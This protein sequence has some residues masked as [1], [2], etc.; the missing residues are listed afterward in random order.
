MWAHLGSIFGIHFTQSSPRVTG[1]AARVDRWYDD[2]S[3][4]VSFR[5]LAASIFRWRFGVVDIGCR[6]ASVD[7][8]FRVSTGLFFPCRHW[9]AFPGPVG[10][11]CR[12]VRWSRDCPNAVR[13]CC[14]AVTIR[15]PL[16]GAVRVGGASAFANPGQLL[17][18]RRTKNTLADVRQNRRE[19]RHAHALRLA[20]HETGRRLVATRSAIEV[21]ASCSRICSF[22]Y[23]EWQTR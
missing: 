4:D 18:N 1:F 13:R 23:Q 12:P 8:R 6:V 15:L 22:L 19:A 3:A 14:Q 9:R 17:R 10:L 16:W 2:E 11:S 5:E 21:D 7:H 20:A